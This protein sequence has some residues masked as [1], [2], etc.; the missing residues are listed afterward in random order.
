MRMGKW[1]EDCKELSEDSQ[2]DIPGGPEVGVHRK[3][4]LTILSCVLSKL[5][6][7][8]VQVKVLRRVVFSC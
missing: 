7:R 6:K 2:E 5:A 4:W 1:L 3:N 8:L